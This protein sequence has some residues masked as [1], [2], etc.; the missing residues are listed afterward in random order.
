MLI[1]YIFAQFAGYVMPVPF[2]TDCFEA[3]YP[4]FYYASGFI[5]IVIG[6]IENW[7]FVYHPLSKN[8]VVD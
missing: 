6:I 8:I 4:I 1:L 2:Y 3:P 5:F 7:T